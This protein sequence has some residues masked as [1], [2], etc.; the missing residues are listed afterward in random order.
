MP[1]VDPDT[2][3]R[4]LA[5]LNKVATTNIAGADIVAVEPTLKPYVTQ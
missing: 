5:R 1:G 3:D 2:V 4:H